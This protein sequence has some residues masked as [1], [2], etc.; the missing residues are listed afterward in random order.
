MGQTSQPTGGRPLAALAVVARFKSHCASA[1]CSDPIHRGD[2][3]VNVGGNWWHLACA[4]RRGLDPGPG[5]D[6]G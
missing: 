6:R 2:E 1:G 3:I 5:E 4:E